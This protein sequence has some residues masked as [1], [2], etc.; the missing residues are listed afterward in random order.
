MAEEGSDKPHIGPHQG[1]GGIFRKVDQANHDLAERLA[2]QGSKVGTKVEPK[3]TTIRTPIMG[4]IAPGQTLAAGVETSAFSAD[5]NWQP[6][7]IRTNAD[8]MKAAGT[9]AV[10]QHEA[11]EGTS[12]TADT[13]EASK[14]ARAI[15]GPLSGGQVTD[16]QRE[17]AATAVAPKVRRP[18]PQDSAPTILS[19]ADTIR[20]LGGHGGRTDGRSK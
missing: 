12:S 11:L 6:N 20:D 9:A 15:F 5:G 8:A 16:A 1:T 14:L 13:S 2:A 17:I 10:I 19:S 4:K 7:W 18:R 3:A